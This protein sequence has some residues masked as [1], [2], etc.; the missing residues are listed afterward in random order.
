MPI[1][2]EMNYIEKM[3]IF[4]GKESAIK[5]SEFASKFENVGILIDKAAIDGVISDVFFSFFQENI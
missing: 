5:V 1:M 2:K 4:Y 3:K